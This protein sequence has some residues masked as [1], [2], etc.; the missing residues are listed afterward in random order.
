MGE[1]EMSFNPDV[2]KSNFTGKFLSWGKL[3][4]GTLQLN[5]EYQ[6]KT[7][8][9]LLEDADLNFQVML[10]QAHYKP[11]GSDM[12][13]PS[14][15]HIIYRADT[16][17]ELGY[18]VTS[19]YVPMSYPEILDGFFHDI[20]QLGGIPSRVVGFDQGKRAAIQFLLPDEY[21]IAGVAHAPFFNLYSSHDT[22]MPIGGNSSN[23]CI[24]C[25]NTMALSYAD[26][27]LKFSI[28]HTRNASNRLAEI[29]NVIMRA[30]EGND[31]YAKALGEFIRYPADYEF[32][33]LFLNSLLPDPQIKPG[34]KVNQARANQREQI[35]V[36]IG[37]SASERN[38]SDVTIYDVFMG[39][40]RYNSYRT[41]NRDDSRQF[42]YVNSG[43][44]AELNASGFS[45][46]KEYVAENQ[47][48][49]VV[50]MP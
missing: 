36:A 15:G 9:D 28:R 21:Y 35:N 27:T 32:Q 12:I 39:L 23:I 22:T 19:R 29:S 33:K 48:K 34:E 37:V 1:N 10:A 42:E 49:L 41:Q 25:G 43:P 40:T 26:K 4:Y 6:N 50:T 45:W 20:K 11:A 24:V 7:V 14:E 2:T 3:D 17:Q 47:P 30:R 8:I 18:G 13:I 38:T 31:E 5:P 44:G 16:M 46:L